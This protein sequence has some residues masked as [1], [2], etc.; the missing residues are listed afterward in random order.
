M[1]KKTG[2]PANLP[3]PAMLHASKTGNDYLYFIHTLLECNYELERINFVGGDRDR[4][5]S[6]FLTLDVIHLE[7]LGLYFGLAAS[8]PFDV[9]E[10]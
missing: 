9:T 1:N 3:G 2:K 5:Q 10:S 8:S 4:A 6:S 7:E